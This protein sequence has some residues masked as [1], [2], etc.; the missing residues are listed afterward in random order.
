[1][2]P[3]RFGIR[4]SDPVPMSHHRIDRRGCR[5]HRGDLDF[6]PKAEGAGEWAFRPGSGEARVAG[7]WAFRPD[8]GEQRE[9]PMRRRRRPHRLASR[10]SSLRLTE[11]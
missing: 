1:M 5:A 8:P 6:L 3:V 7:E 9:R 2:V 10:H 4:R 11:R